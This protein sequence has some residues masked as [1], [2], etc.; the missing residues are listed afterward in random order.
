MGVIDVLEPYIVRM[1]SV[2][3]PEKHVPFKRKLTWTLGVL[4]LYF[5]LT[6]VTVYGAD[7]QGDLFGQFRSVLAGAQGSV[8]HLGIGPIVTA[9]IVLQLLDGSDLLPFDTSEP[10]GQALYQ[11]SQKVLVV[12]MSILTAA[13]MVATGF[14]TPRADL[15]LS[16]GAVA[17]IVFLQVALG[18][19]IILYLDEIISKWG[20]GS[21]VGLFIV[22]GVSQQMVGGIF[23]WH[24]DPSAELAEL[25]VGLLFRWYHIATGQSPL[26]TEFAATSSEG[27][28][29]LMTYGGQL[30][31]V[32]TTILVFAIIVYAESVRVEIP[33]SHSR[34][35]GAR[36]R[37]PVKLIYASVL[38]LIF[39][40]AIQ[41]N[42]QM[43]GQVLYSRGFDPE[44][45]AVYDQGVAQSGIM[46]YLTPVY[47]PEDWMWWLPTGPTQEVHQVLLRLGVDLTFLMVGGAIFAVFWVESA[48]MGPGAVAQQIQRSGMQIPG[49][50]RNPGVIEKVMERYIPPI[51]ILSGILIGLIAALANL[52]GTIGGV[53]GLGLLLAVS[54]T[55]KLYEEIAEEQMM[56]MHPMMRRMF[57]QE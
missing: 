53:D 18:G 13:P 42:F 43:L 19:V 52:L 47:R 20:I 12:L 40:R 25:P 23:D 45:F 41:A 57:G 5:A 34:V 36:G 44:W 35:K 17:W 15:G 33:L 30:L 10:R 24:S 16:V 48:D 39:V 51:T 56:E 4:V 37:Y 31:F 2:S 9:S 6:N 50:R 3:R 11:G 32:I 49:F 29:F 54:I 8:L 26:G 1:P 27:F 28:W 46:W 22:A 21:G 7:V 38:P 55:Y 14:L